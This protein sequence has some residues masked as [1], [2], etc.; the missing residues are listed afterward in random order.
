V[1]GADGGDGFAGAGRYRFRI[2]A[3]NAFGASDYS[4]ELVAAIAPLPGAFA[5]VTK[6]ALHSTSTSI[7]VQWVVPGSEVEPVLGYRL[8]MV[9]EQTES[10]TTVY[11]APTNPHVREYLAP[12]LTPGNRYTFSVWAY[13]FNGLGPAGSPSATFEACSAPSGVPI[14][15]VTARS[16]TALSFAWAEPSDTGGCP[17]TGYAFYRDDGA[18]GAWEPAVTL[19]AHLKSVTITPTPSTLGSRYRY[20]L[21]ASNAIGPGAGPVGLTLFAAVPTKP[22]SGT[23]G[24]ASDPAVTGKDL[25]KATWTATA[26]VAE[27]GGAE[28]LSYQL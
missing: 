2:R 9:D 3:V 28:V 26:T 15:T 20:K 25:I 10:T 22:S 17:V 18:G 23:A 19:A 11:D 12:G 7:K 21:E 13:N 14:P 5:A 1:S 27:H 4:P 24:P 8:R 6:D 16:S